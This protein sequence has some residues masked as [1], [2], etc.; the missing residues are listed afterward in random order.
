MSRNWGRRRRGRE[1]RAYDQKDQKVIF[2]PS[3]IWR[4]SVSVLPIAATEGTTAPEAL[5]SLMLS[6]SGPGRLKFARLNTLKASAR[7]WTLFVS[8]NAMFFTTA[9]SK[10]ARPGPMT[11]L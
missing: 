6:V 10:F 7:N 8:F 1:A 11:V 2:S 3:W 9:K 5:N 4:E